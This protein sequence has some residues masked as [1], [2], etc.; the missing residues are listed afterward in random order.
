MSIA[1]AAECAG[2]CAAIVL[3][4]CDNFSR[5]CISSLSW[6]SSSSLV[7]PRLT[8]GLFRATQAKSSFQGTSSNRCQ[9]ERQPLR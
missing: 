3:T 2:I 5:T 1:L 9:V 7:E 8:A 4:D 6:L